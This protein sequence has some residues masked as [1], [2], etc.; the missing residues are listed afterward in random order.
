MFAILNF[1]QLFENTFEIYINQPRSL[2]KN[3]IKKF[4]T[5][6]TLKLLSKKGRFNPLTF[7]IHRRLKTF[8][9]TLIINCKKVQFEGIY[10][11]NYFFF[12]LKWFTFL[13]FPLFWVLRVL[14]KNERQFFSR[15]LLIKNFLLYPLY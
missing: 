4:K 5:F 15:D 2:L 9:Q 14:N 10:F 12:V 8:V 1:P 6:Y 11:S 3:L 7:L 13:G